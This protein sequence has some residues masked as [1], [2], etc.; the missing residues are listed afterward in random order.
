MLTDL[1]VQENGDVSKFNPVNTIEALSQ[2][3]RYLI[4]TTEMTREDLSKVAANCP[5]DEA[6]KY[7]HPDF[8][9]RVTDQ[10]WN[11]YVTDLLTKHFGQL[12]NFDGNNI[13]FANYENPE[14]LD[15][16]RAYAIELSETGFSKQSSTIKELIESC[17]KVCNLFS[18]MP[19]HELGM[20]HILPIRYLPDITTAFPVWYYGDSRGLYTRNHELNHLL[21]EQG[22]QNFAWFAQIYSTFSPGLGDFDSMED[23]MPQRVMKVLKD[24]REHC[25]FCTIATPYHDIASKAWNDVEL[26]R[27]LVDPLLFGHVRNFPYIFLFAR[28]SGSGIF[29]GL[30][31]MIHATIEHLRQNKSDLSH[32]RRN[33]PWYAGQ[34]NWQL[35]KQGKGKGAITINT[36]LPD[37][38]DKLIDAYDQ[39]RLFEFLREKA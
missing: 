9:P 16:V 17:Q 26:Q 39:S 14:L 38:A 23:P 19:R 24:V 22:S 13:D 8:N 33:T 11:R 21:K 10:Q 32:I 2:N 29:P 1:S 15:D 12:L 35:Q 31:N 3:T 37:F 7:F 18:I 25:D 5:L 36:L 30:P 6:L 4:P 27:M 34:A 28:W 20:L